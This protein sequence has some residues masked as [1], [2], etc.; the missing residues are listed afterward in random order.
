MKSINVFMYNCQDIV[1]SISKKGTESDIALYNRK[2]DNGV[3]TLIE[4]IRYPDKISPLT[5]SLFPADVAV[6]SARKI[7][8]E[9]GEVLIASDL[10]GKSKA[11]FVTDDATDVALLKRLVS[12]TGIGDASFFSGSPVELADQIWGYYGAHDADGTQVIVDHSFLVKSVGL[13]ALGFV[14]SGTVKKHQ[15]LHNTGGG[16]DVQVRSIQMQDIDFDEAETGSRVGLALKNADLEHVFRGSVLSA[17]KIP[18]TESIASAVSVH[19]S[20]KT[21]TQDG[22]EVFIS[23]FMRYQRGSIRGSTV[24]LDRPVPV[25]RRRVAIASPTASPRV[26]GYASM[27]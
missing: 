5:D 18:S 15:D 3:I 9:F 12:Q 20:L 8:R 10:M 22:M 7:D 14:M 11:I 19:P 23:D 21:K 17:S 1:K 27:E 2:D 6:I 13:V 16:P 24:V 26:F 4:P 25:L